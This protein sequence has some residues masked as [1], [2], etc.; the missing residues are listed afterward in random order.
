MLL[1]SHKWESWWSHVLFKW[2]LWWLCE[3]AQATWSSDL[4]VWMP[5]FGGSR[6]YCKHWNA[7]GF[8]S[9][10]SSLVCA[11][12]GVLVLFLDLLALRRQGVHSIASF[13][14]ALWVGVMLQKQ[15]WHFCELPQTG[16]LDIIELKLIVR[17]EILI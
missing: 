3:R 4:V 9:V 15:I 5:S 6:N 7:I 10:N 2:L 11:M 12:S 13:I 17:K 14:Q 16:A 8:C 1:T